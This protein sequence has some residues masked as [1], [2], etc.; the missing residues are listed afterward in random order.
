MAKSK[1]DSG[2]TAL[3][4]APMPQPVDNETF[5]QPQA[6]PV[7]IGD[8]RAT[9][10]TGFLRIPV[11]ELEIN[12]ARN[13][14]RFDG[15]SAGLLELAASIKERES[16]TPGQGQIQPIGVR[17]R[18]DKGLYPVV[19]GFRRSMAISHLNTTE[20]MDLPVLARIITPDEEEAMLMNLS[21]NRDRKDLT[22]IDMAFALDELVKSGMEGKAVAKR[23]KKSA[24]WVSQ[25]RGFLKLPLKYQKLLHE[26]KLSHGVA[27]SMAGLEEAA[28][29]RLWAKHVQ[30]V[31][32]L[33]MTEAREVELA[34]NPGKKK[35]KKKASKEGKPLSTKAVL[36]VFTEY[37]V[38][39]K[40]DEDGKKHKP[41][42]IEQARAHVCGLAVKLMSGALGAQG[43]V[44]ALEKALA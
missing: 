6:E 26:G 28:Q 7:V 3:A 42:P 4:D 37:A 29:D 1:K 20:G 9:E 15:D 27:R 25:V 44:K 5:T 33:E 11:N 39:P 2:N 31:S 22:W 12:S 17:E 40:E 13:L 18:N 41:T 14:R 21:E 38:V 16:N 24:G 34:A 10:A 35:R 32:R 30:G 8:T 23:F 19:F 36:R 43:F